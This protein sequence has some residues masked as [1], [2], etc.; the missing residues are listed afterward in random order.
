MT[1]DELKQDCKNRAIFLLSQTDWVTFSDVATGNP[2]L[3]NQSDFLIYRNII[4]NLSINPV[5]DPD[6]PTIPTEQWSN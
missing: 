5:I 4:R 6:F 2:K 1:N 3:I